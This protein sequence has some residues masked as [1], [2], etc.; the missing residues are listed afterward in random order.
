[1]QT[2]FRQQWQMAKTYPVEGMIL[3]VMMS[4]AFIIRLSLIDWMSGDYLNF[5]K[6]WMQEIVAGGRIASL[7]TR[8]GDYSPP[9][10]YV[11]TFLSYFP[12]AN[13]LDPYLVGI[14][15]VSWIFDGVLA[16][17]VYLHARRWTM[18]IHPMMPLAI[19]VIVLFL[20]TVII[21]GSLWG[22]IDAI[23]TALALI[24]LDRL[25]KDKVFAASIWF[26]VAISVKLQ[27]IFFLPVFILYGWFRYRDRL[28]YLLFIP[29]VYLILA[30]PA[31]LAGRGF[32]DV[33]NIYFLQSQSY[34]YM[35]LNMPNLYQ[36][37]PPGRYETLSVVAF[38]W[39]ASLMAFNMVMMLFHKVSLSHTHLMM[40]TLWSVLMANYFLPAMHERYLF[41]AD[42]IVVLWVFQRKQDWWMVMAIQA[43]SLL[44]Y[45]PYI[46]GMEPIPLEWVSLGYA[47]T[48]AY[49]TR[50]MWS[51]WISAKELK[52]E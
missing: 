44:A 24:S 27:A 19:A 38:A 2:W 49:M 37:F 12:S 41:A 47:A 8:I 18:S 16:Y 33:L 40:M 25:H 5:L 22:Q 28:H 36:W 46:F 30:I 9:Y 15:I 26:G 48:L 7:G 42:V 50:V 32:V 14:K 10:M 21:N 31:F 11:L 23:Y 51:T 35:T 17:A 43:I 3:F 13:A 4:F 45:S 6:P 34:P 1:M 52:R 20:P 39:F 29:L